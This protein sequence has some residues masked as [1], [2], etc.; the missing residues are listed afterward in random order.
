[1]GHRANLII[2]KDAA[3]SLYYSHWCA[4]TMP[5]N[6]F[7]GP[8]AA[9]A[10]IERQEPTTGWLDSAWAEG[11]ALVDL[12]R[13]YLL[14]YGGE[15]TK[16]EIPLRR[17][18]IR[19]MQP[20]WPGWTI[21]W[22]AAGILDMA[23]YL[24]YP[25]VK[26]QSLSKEPSASISLIPEPKDGWVR[27][28][29]SM[30]YPDGELRVY[31][32]QSEVEE[33]LL[34]GPQLLASLEQSTGCRELDLNEWPKETPDQ[35][36]HLDLRAGTIDIWYA[37]DIGMLLHQIRALW[38]GWIVTDRKDQYES[39]I[40]LAGGRIRFQTENWEEL[41]ERLT[42]SLLGSHSS[43]VDFIRQVAQLKEEAGEQLEINPHALV[44]EPQDVPLNT[45][46]KL[47]HYA[48]AN[49]AEA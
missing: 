11:G 49:M 15:D 21:E 8:E 2:I 36:F 7:W 38:P 17:H 10:F 44:D 1:M 28:L 6:L 37:P 43:P 30:I 25:S 29:A 33:Y 3:Y 46:M 26:L 41:T 45:R 16:Y 5:N 19:M 24:G 14:W 23:A 48:I 22:A 42:T 13:K 27:T 9:V 47:L 20:L 12:D 18:L 4:N 34:Q 40:R 32:V 35:G 31:P 39:Q